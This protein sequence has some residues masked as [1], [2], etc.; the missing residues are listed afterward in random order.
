MKLNLV[1]L[2][3]SF[4]INRLRHSPNNLR[5]SFSHVYYIN[6]QNLHFFGKTIKLPIELVNPANF[7]NSTKKLS[8]F[9]TFIAFIKKAFIVNFNKIS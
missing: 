5:V 2:L 1:F 7:S 6:Y 9:F 3:K 8:F 4:R